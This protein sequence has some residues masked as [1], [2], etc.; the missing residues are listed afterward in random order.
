MSSLLAAAPCFSSASHYKFF[1]FLSKTGWLIIGI[2]AIKRA[3]ELWVFTGAGYF[4]LL[5]MVRSTI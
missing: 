3:S 5:I 4:N 2:L 1:I